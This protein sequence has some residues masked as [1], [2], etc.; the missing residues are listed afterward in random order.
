MLIIK[1]FRAGGSE[2]RRAYICNIHSCFQLNSYLCAL[3][4]NIKYLETNALFNR[5]QLDEIIRRAPEYLDF[6]AANKLWRHYYQSYLVVT[7]VYR[8]NGEYK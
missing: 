6:L 4:F 3:I 7:G 2:L 5:Q 1:D 8:R